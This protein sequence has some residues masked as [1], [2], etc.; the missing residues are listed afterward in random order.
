MTI[1]QRSGMLKT[2]ELTTRHFGWPRL[3]KAAPE[4]EV[5]GYLLDRSLQSQGL[6]SLDS[7][8]HLDA[9]RKSAVRKLIEARVRRKE[10]MPIESEGAG[11]LQHWV[12]PE[13]VET[14]LSRPTTS[15]TS[16]RRS[17]R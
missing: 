14:F 9:Q 10:L 1:S 3:P 11:K 2:Y 12:R 4:R 7:I 8:C 6:V 15:C 17:T 16:C 13:I 5:L